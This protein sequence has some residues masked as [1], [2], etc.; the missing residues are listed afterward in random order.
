MRKILTGGLMGAAVCGLLALSVPAPP[1]ASEVAGVGH[2]LHQDG[3]PPLL[4]AQF[5]MPGMGGGMGMGGM[6]MGGMGMGGAGMGGGM[7]GFGGQMAQFQGGGFPRGGFAELPP[8]QPTQIAAL[9]T[10]LL[11]DPPDG[12]TRFVGGATAD[13]SAVAFADGSS[14]S[15][16]QALGRGLVGIRGRDDSYDPVRRDGSLALDL[17]LV[18]LTRLPARLELVAGTTITPRGQ[19]QQPL[20]EAADRLFALGQQRNLSYTNTMQFAVW[21]AR[22]STAED[23]EQTQM[24]SLP[25]RE[26]ARVQGLLTASGAIEVFDRERG[27]YEALYARAEKELPAEADPLAGSTTLAGA[28]RAQV[29]GYRL[30]DGTGLVTVAPSRGGE[31]FYRAEFKDRRDGKV[32]VRLTHLVSGRPIR[33]NGGGFLL[34]P[35]RTAEAGTRLA[36]R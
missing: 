23:V 14:F 32:E 2:A 16:A 25:D 15:L 6:G 22:G 20:P 29:E 30:P 26:L 27:R 35:T 3:E 12:T 9:C 11:S 36:S 1:A 13:R 17:Y 28:R 18:N 33:A 24:V 10:D 34:T 7:G 31:F 8:G 4:L 19:A 5:G 21:G